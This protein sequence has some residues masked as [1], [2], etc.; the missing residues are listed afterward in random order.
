MLLIPEFLPTD[1]TFSE[2]VSVVFDITINAEY[3]VEIPLVLPITTF[4]VSPSF[5][6]IRYPLTIPSG[7]TAWLV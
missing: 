2:V 1:E 7:F 4:K 3:S 6:P 5:A